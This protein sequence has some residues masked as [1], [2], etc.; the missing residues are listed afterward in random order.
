[1]THRLN[2]EKTKRRKLAA[3]L[4]KSILHFIEWYWWKSELKRDVSLKS[5]IHCVFLWW[6]LG[7]RQKYFTK[8]SAWLYLWSIQNIPSWNVLFPKWTVLG[9]PIMR[10]LLKHLNCLTSVKKQPM[11]PVLGLLLKHLKW[12]VLRIHHSLTEFFAHFSYTYFNIFKSEGIDIGKIFIYEV[13]QWYC[14][15]M[16]I[17]LLLLNLKQIIKQLDKGEQIVI[18]F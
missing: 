1:M 8:I 15:Y 7:K 12:S 2:V 16:H 9:D 4:I 14:H 3:H 10:P 18:G 6:P 5:E 13:W 11:W 17:M